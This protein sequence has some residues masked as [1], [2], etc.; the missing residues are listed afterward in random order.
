[1]GKGRR[2]SKKFGL[3]AHDFFAGRRPVL[4]WLLDQPRSSHPRERRPFLPGPLHHVSIRSIRRSKPSSKRT[5]TFSSSLLADHGLINVQYRDLKAFPAFKESALAKPMRPGRAD[6]PR[7]FLKEGK[8]EQFVQA[9]T[10]EF[11]ERFALKLRRTTSSK[12]A[13][14][15]KARSTRKAGSRSA[16]TSP[17]PWA[18]NCSA[19]PRFLRNIRSTKATMPARAKRNAKSSWLAITANDRPSSEGLFL[20][21]GPF[22]P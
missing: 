12:K 6:R 13:T 22:L 5:P 15:A 21:K 3:H 9:F 17:L 10:K 1:M 19:I 4:L 11:P 20:V 8:E 2:A 18:I 7:F 16:I 14:S